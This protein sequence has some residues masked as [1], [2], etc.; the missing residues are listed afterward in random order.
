MNLSHLK[1]GTRL[2][3]GFGVVVLLLAAVALVAITRINLINQAT[4]R[5]LSD[6]FVKLTLAR[7]IQTEVNV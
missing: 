6:S 1:I 5:I 3:L 7:Q 2:G 4:E